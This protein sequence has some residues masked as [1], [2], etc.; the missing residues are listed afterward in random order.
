MK[1]RLKQILKNQSIIDSKLSALM[2]S[3]GIELMSL[4]TVN[5]TIKPPKPPKGG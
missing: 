5:P 3:S 4:D 2:Y 1:K